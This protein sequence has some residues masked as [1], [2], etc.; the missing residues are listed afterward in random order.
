MGRTCLSSMSFRKL[1]DLCKSEQDVLARAENSGSEGCYV[2]IARWNPAYQM[3][4]NPQKGG[5]NRFAFDNF[6]TGQIWKNL[7]AY[8]TAERI[9]GIINLRGNQ[10]AAN[11]IHS[12]PNF[13]PSNP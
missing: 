13:F 5:W 9:A 8:E 1:L 10:H 4:G 7:S 11:L 3:N 12:L 2:E 6:F